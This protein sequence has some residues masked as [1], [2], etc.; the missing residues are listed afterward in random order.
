M[1]RTARRTA[2]RVLAAL[3]SL[4][5]AGRPLPGRAQDAPDVMALVR[6]DRW[7]EAQAAVAGDA[8]P[9]AAKLVTYFRLQAPYAANASEIDVFMRENPDWP[10]QAGLARR[11]DD[12]LAVEPDD[13][14]A[15]TLCASSTPTSAGALLRCSDAAAQAGHAEAAAGLARQAWLAG[16]AD[17]QLEA[18]FLAKW[19]GIVSAD[20]Q[21]RRFLRLAAGNAPAAA[22]QMAR[23]DAPHRQAAETLLALRHD[24]PHADALLAAL[25]AALRD[26]PAVLLE[27]ARHLRRTGQ[28]AAALAL[29][30]ADGGAARGQATPDELRAFWGERNQLARALLQDGDA[31]GAY[32]LAAAN[33]QTDPETVADAEFLAGW[34]ALRRLGRPADAT[35]HF[36][37]L[38]SVSRAAITQGRARYWL[39][40]AAAARG[41]AVEAQ[42]EYALG[43]RWLTTFYGQLC[44]LRLGDDSAAL[45]RRIRAAADPAW[46]PGQALDF[47]G[48]EVARAAVML[49]GWGDARR[50]RPFLLQL[51]A[52]APDPADRA[53]AARLALGLGMPDQAVMI[54]RR[55]GLHATMLPHAG[56]PMPYQPPAGVTDPALALGVMRQESSFDAGALSP[57]G[58][59]GLMQLMPATARAVSRQTGDA[60][61]AAALSGDPQANMRLGTDYLADLVAQFNGAVPLAVAAYN[62]GPARVQQWLA[63]NGDPTAGPPRLA[64]AGSAAPATVTVVAAPPDM[65][66][67][68]ELI[69][70]NETRNYVQRVIENTVIY[71]AL[72]DDATPHPLARWLG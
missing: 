46:Q 15:L 3:L 52:L 40:R 23:L 6:A 16:M 55:A 24:D 4:A 19:G 44:A 35:Q 11:R 68:I 20:D 17:P 56:W 33:G 25:P 58:A 38:L 70:F 67:W 37:R 8:D 65:I 36:L 45:Y 59:R 9:V 7:A 64:Q 5:A 14:V 54:A 41:D 21:W 61:D 48:R 42:A 30:R 53:L 1:R 39:G 60:G 69:P 27:L 43:A 51:E 72:L 57:A 47:A 71:R 2:R 32:A 28:T 22:R 10:N 50:A 62:A 34:I 18:R 29:W 63:E 26:D 13:T 31:D 66:D 49:V 12:A